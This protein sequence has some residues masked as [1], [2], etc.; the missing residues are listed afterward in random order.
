MCGWRFEKSPNEPNKLISTYL[1][2]N[3]V[4]IT[5]PDDLNHI[6]DYLNDLNAMHKVE[7]TQLNDPFILR[8]Y[9]WQLDEITGDTWN[10]ILA[11]A[12]ERAEAFLITMEKG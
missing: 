5:D 7:T 11:T 10:T 12:S 3:D 9:F 6:P 4:Y 8:E 1:P 2:T